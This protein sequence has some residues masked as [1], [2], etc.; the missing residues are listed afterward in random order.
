M[1][2]SFRRCQA[3]KDGRIDDDQVAE[4]ATALE[5]QLRLV[6]GVYIDRLESAS[7]A[8]PDGL[9]V[10]ARLRYKERYLHVAEVRQNVTRT[11]RFDFFMVFSVVDAVY[12]ID[13]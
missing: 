9:A 3:R 11:L 13:V 7:D 10:T 12:E 6:E 5:S 8:A 1:R 2:E 4:L